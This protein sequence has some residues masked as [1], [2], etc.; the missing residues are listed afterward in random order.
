[1]SEDDHRENLRLVNELCGFSGLFNR[2]P[3][4]SFNMTSFERQ[5]S[6]HIDSKENGLKQ[7]EMS[8]TEADQKMAG[9]PRLEI[10]Q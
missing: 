3:S 2:L 7:R 1:M 10:K 4:T 6:M 5:Q 8:D 9:K